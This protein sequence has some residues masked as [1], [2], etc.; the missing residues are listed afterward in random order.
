VDTL[1]SFHKFHDRIDI[2]AAHYHEVRRPDSYHRQLGC[3]STLEILQSDPSS[4]YSA[5]LERAPLHLK[6]CGRLRIERLYVLAHQVGPDYVAKLT[7]CV[8]MISDPDIYR[9]YKIDAKHPYRPL[10]G[11]SHDQL[12]TIANKGQLEP[13]PE[14]EVPLGFVRTFGVWED[15]GVAGFDPALG[16]TRIIGHTVTANKAPRVP[17]QI[18]GSTIK[19]LRRFCSDNS[20]AITFDF[21]QFYS[22]IEL[23]KD[24]RNFFTF[25]DSTGAWWR[26]TRLSMGDSHSAD[27]AQL[28]LE[29]FLAFVKRNFDGLTTIGHVD[30]GLIGA[31]DQELLRQVADFVKGNADMLG[32]KINDPEMIVPSQTI[33]FCGLN[34]NFTDKVMT[35]TKKTVNKSTHLIAALKTLIG[36]QNQLIAPLRLVACAMGLVFYRHSLFRDSNGGT[37]PIMNQFKMVSMFR[38]ISRSQEWDTWF[39]FPQKFFA[40]LIDCLMWVQRNDPI[41]MDTIE[42]TGHFDALAFVDASAIMWGATTVTAKGKHEIAKGYFANNILTRSSVESEPTGITHHVISLIKRGFKNIA[43]GIDHDSFRKAFYKGLSPNWR[44]NISLSEIR[45]TAA[46]HGAHITLFYI[47]GTLNPADEISRNMELI[48]S[49]LREA[50]E[51]AQ[52]TLGERV[53]ILVDPCAA[54]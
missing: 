33:E 51:F 15:K 48:Q 10:V 45:Q 3:P 40:P 38:T 5:R 24:V 6:D 46:E 41:G 43:V 53:S 39:D 20:Y 13:L 35:T 4:G 18:E 2:L 16:R 52:A 14:G 22:S 12:V 50:I 9:P 8:K 54:R 23:G 25:Q 31:N 28:V 1:D 19:K 7:D 29:I 21:Q 37:T 49:K 34:L 42:G 44:Y 36:P 26:L 32:I 27:F 30:N 11:F 17:W 47:P